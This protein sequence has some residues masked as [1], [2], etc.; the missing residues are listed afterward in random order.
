MSG[1]TPQ[2]DFSHVTLALPPYRESR[3]TRLNPHI[4]RHA[5][6]RLPSGR[7]GWLQLVASVNLPFSAV[8]PTLR[9]SMSA[10]RFQK[11]KLRWR[12]MM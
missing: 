10:R 2:S 9:R 6:R 8:A 5:S 11:T 7:C 1:M 4:N 12:R 3:Q